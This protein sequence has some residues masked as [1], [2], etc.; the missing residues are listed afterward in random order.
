MSAKVVDRDLGLSERV[1]AVSGKWH[2][3]VGVLEDAKP[4]DDN[5]TNPEIA[6]FHEFGL[7]VP[8]RSFVRRTA[9]E[10]ISE[11][12][13]TQR[14]VGRDILAG[15]IDGEQGANRLGIAVA[16]LMKTRV[17]AFIPPPLSAERI[18]QK[19]STVPPIDKGQLRSSISHQVQKGAVKP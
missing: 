12:Q 14:A 19:G 13:N 15:K 8:E 1:K 10:K 9:D 16:G 2:V 5:A 4:R 6:A 11:I 17:A 7:G 3:K 18:K